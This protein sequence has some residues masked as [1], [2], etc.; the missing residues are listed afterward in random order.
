MLASRSG[1]NELKLNPILCV[2]CWTRTRPHSERMQAH[3]G[4]HFRTRVHTENSCFADVDGKQRV[5]FGYTCRSSDRE[6]QFLR[7]KSCA[8]TKVQVTLLSVRTATLGVD[9]CNLVAVQTPPAKADR[10]AGAHTGTGEPSTLDPKYITSRMD[11]ASGQPTGLPYAMEATGLGP[12]SPLVF[13]DLCI[14]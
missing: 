1:L 12:A 4:N 7:G 6:R 14:P 9:D 11:K 13:K 2:G 5:L 10:T 3:T 8:Q